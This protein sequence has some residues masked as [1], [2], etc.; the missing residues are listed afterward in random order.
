MGD[1]LAKV[2][3]SSS[4]CLEDHWYPKLCVYLRWEATFQLAKSCDLRLVWHKVTTLKLCNDGYKWITTLYR[5]LSWWSNR[6]F[7]QNLWYCQKCGIIVGMQ[8][9]KKWWCW[10]KFVQ[11][12]LIWAWYSFLTGLGCV[13]KIERTSTL[14]RNKN[15]VKAALFDKTHTKYNLV[16]RLWQY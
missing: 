12:A 13:L 11:V 2:W 16:R 3:E 6:F 5:M 10:T 8:S 14:A 9:Y 15:R 7:H 1:V 4:T